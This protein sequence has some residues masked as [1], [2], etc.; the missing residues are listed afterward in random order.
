M[1]TVRLVFCSPICL[2]TNVYSSWCCTRSD[3]QES[4]IVMPYVGLSDWSLRYLSKISFFPNSYSSPPGLRLNLMAD[5]AH[6]GDI[7]LR[8]INYDQLA[9]AWGLSL[10]STLMARKVRK[11]KSPCTHNTST[12]VARPSHANIHNRQN[13]EC[14]DF[15]PFITETNSNYILHEWVY[16]SF[17]FWK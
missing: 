10:P 6:F 16:L 14:N 8:F 13:R 17:R 7:M 9:W 4:T 5:D 2:P 3:S 11:M 12:R 1:H 15:D